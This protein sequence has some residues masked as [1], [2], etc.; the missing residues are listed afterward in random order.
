MSCW[1]VPSVAAEIWGVSV[2]EVLRRIQAREVAWREENGWT[3]VDVAPTSPMIGPPL[4]RGG[5]KPATFTIISS[6]EM[7]ALC[8]DEIEEPEVSTFKDWRQ[9]RQRTSR[10]RLA[11]PKFVSV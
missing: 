3:F 11:P 8:E 6:E 4:K 2:G 9:A 7:E 1:V 10:M 5:P